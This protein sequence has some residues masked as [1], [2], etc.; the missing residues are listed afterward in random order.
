LDTVLQIGLTTVAILGIV[1]LLIG[2]ILLSL[3]SVMTYKFYKFMKKQKALFD[4][5]EKAFSFLNW[6]K[7]RG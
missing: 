7:K 2:T 1:F 6:F 3:L 5:V 4:E